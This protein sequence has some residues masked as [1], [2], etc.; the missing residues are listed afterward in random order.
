MRFAST[1]AL[2]AA[3]PGLSSGFSMDPCRIPLA[4]DLIP[5]VAS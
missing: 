4:T 5:D 2:Y 3:N 1:V